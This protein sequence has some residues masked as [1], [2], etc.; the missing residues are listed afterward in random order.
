MTIYKLIICITVI[1][2]ISSCGTVEKKKELNETE[3][4]KNELSKGIQKDTV[5]LGYVFG[6][7]RKQT[8]K[9]TENLYKAGTPL[10]QSSLSGLWEQE[11]GVRLAFGRFNNVYLDYKLSF[12]ENKLYKVSVFGRIGSPKDKN[13]I[14]WFWAFV[15]FYKTK[16]GKPTLTES[17]YSGLKIIDWIEGNRKI[18]IV[19][20]PYQNDINI[21]SS[22]EEFQ[23]TII[24]EDVLASREMENKEKQDKDSINKIIRDKSKNTI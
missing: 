9:H 5:F 23:I 20:I 22:T 12:F 6:M 11:C 13:F 21:N 16:Y 7:N 14:D 4:I 2:I 8:Q 15:N 19:P 24:Y 17:H 3:I 18:Q 1:F 10:T